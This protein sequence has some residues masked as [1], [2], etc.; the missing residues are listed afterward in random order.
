MTVEKFKYIA[1]V[2]GYANETKV[3]KYIKSVGRDVF[4]EDDFI[5]LY[6]HQSATWR[7]YVSC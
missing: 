1:M 7:H 6:R 4:D 3:D 2:C 5:K